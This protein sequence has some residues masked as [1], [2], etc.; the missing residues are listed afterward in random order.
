MSSEVGFRRKHVPLKW[1][2]AGALVVGLAVF[3]VQFLLASEQLASV[4]L[5][6]SEGP[7]ANIVPRV[8]ILD[9]RGEVETRQPTTES[10]VDAGPLIDTSSDL[11]NP[12]PIRLKL[13]GVLRFSCRRDQTGLIV[14]GA[15]FD[16]RGTVPNVTASLQVATR[17]DGRVL[18][19]L[20]IKDFSH[21]RGTRDFNSRITAQVGV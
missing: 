2:L 21:L 17:S 11:V 10:R 13:V 7:L 9:R 16:Q 4:S 12:W 18:L 20:P 8:D 5:S 19:D 15:V 1:I 3:S 6:P 14:D